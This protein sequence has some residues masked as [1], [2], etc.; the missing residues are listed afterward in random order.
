MARPGGEPAVG[1]GLALSAAPSGEAWEPQTRSDSP[2]LRERIRGTAEVA[3]SEEEPDEAWMWLET[4]RTG[5]V[6]A[7]HMERR[8]TLATWQ[9]KTYMGF[10]E[11]PARDKAHTARGSPGEEGGASGS[12]LTDGGEK[13][14]WGPWV[15]PAFLDGGDSSDVDFVV[16]VMQKLPHVTPLTPDDIV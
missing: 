5:T 10:H 8:P 11:W 13:H 3:H 7:K 2:G 16:S 6:G 1:G 12:S 15:G 9:E 14:R 4:Y